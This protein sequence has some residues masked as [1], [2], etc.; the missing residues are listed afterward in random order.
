M[1]M[2]FEHQHENKKSIVCQ[3]Q[4]RAT[5]AVVLHHS[6]ALERNSRILSF[7]LVQGFVQENG[8]LIE[9]KIRKIIC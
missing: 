9:A 7:V 3:K 6:V 2:N 8:E 5:K 1:E 4:T